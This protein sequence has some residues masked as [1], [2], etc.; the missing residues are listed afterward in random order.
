MLDLGLIPGTVVSAVVTTMAEMGKVAHA[1]SSD[2]VAP[3]MPPNVTR[4]I[5][6]VAEIS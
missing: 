3:M 5:E 4:T 6:P 1:G 2:S